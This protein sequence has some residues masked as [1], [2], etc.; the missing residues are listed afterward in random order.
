MLCRADNE[1]I[2]HLFF[3]CAYAGTVWER[4][5]GKMDFSSNPRLDL[6]L[7]HIIKNWW[8]NDRVRNYEAL[9]VPLSLPFGKQGIRRFFKTLGIHQR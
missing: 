8:N 4:T 5:T 6:S 9:P 7:E 2:S 1:T 3:S